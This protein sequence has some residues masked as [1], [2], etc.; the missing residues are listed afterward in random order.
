MNS[1]VIP[2]YNVF[3]KIEGVLS[4]IPNIIDR[5]YV[6]NDASTDNTL[7]VLKNYS[8]IDKRIIVVSIEK[9]LGV[10]GAVKAGLF[11]AINDGCNIIIKIDGDGQMEP[12][13]IP[14]FIE[15]LS[16]NRRSF[17]KANRFHDLS[18]L[19]KMPLIRRIGNIALTFLIRLSSGYWGISDPT[20]GYI[21]FS[22]EYLKNIDFESF[23]NRYFFESSIF[24]EL[25]FHKIK[26]IELPISA[27]YNDEV[28]NLSVLNTLFSFPPKIIKAFF[29]RILLD[30]F[31]YDYNIG[32]VY[33]TFGL[34]FFTY[35]AL[36]G[37]Y[38]WS[39]NHSLGVFTPH[40]TALLSSLFTIVGL[41]FLIN[42]LNYDV[43]V[44]NVKTETQQ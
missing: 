29:K 10:G 41:L 40:G 9:N 21:G 24:N 11:K 32:S 33:L 4:K 42:F 5:I 44:N 7:D 18:G 37:L 17:V 23:H 25:H 13:H 6:V 16:R 1:V 43:S 36:K 20:N 35:G 39:Y 26:V 27:V 8:S 3:D 14:K 34:P 30:Y 31:L 2:C 19:K 15:T 28:S 38:N 22:S 12:R